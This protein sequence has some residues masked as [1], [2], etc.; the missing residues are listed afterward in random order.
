MIEACSWSTMKQLTTKCYDGNLRALISAT[1]D[2][3]HIDTDTWRFMWFSGFR[4]IHYSNRKQKFGQSLYNMYVSLLLTRHRDN[5]VA[6][7]VILKK[8]NLI[9]RLMKNKRMNIQLR[10]RANW[11]LKHLLRKENTKLLSRNKS[12]QKKSLKMKKHWFSQIKKVN[13]NS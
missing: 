1:M 8:R 10:T 4:R 11:T 6:K 3:V 12:F 5:R 9:P 7:R 13:Q 2:A